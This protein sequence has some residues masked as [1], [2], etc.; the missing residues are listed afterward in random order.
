MFTLYSIHPIICSG[1]ECWK[2]VFHIVRI[3]YSWASDICYNLCGY[4]LNSHFPLFYFRSISILQSNHLSVK[5]SETGCQ[6]D[7]GLKNQALPL[8]ICITWDKYLT[9]GASVFPPM[10]LG[11]TV[12]TL[13]DCFE[14]QIRWHTWKHSVLCF[15]PTTCLIKVSFLPW[16]FPSFFLP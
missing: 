3:T 8:N 12:S 4:A 15:A 13:Q 2:S 16:F 6:V 11:V 10:K 14:I 5:K 1:T 9:F 7:L